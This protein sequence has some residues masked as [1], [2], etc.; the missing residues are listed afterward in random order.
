V[1][2]PATVPT[3]A[4]IANAVANALGVRVT[5]LP[6]TPDKVLAALGK[7]PKSSGAGPDRTVL[8]QAFT[9]VAQSPA[10][11][12]PPPFTARRRRAYA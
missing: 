2:E 11:P 8:E 1:G 5:S 12:M 4:A 9:R 7:L 3:A 6:I 10:V